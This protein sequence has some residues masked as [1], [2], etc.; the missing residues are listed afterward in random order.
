MSAP[1]RSCGYFGVPHL[2]AIFRTVRMFRKVVRTPSARSSTTFENV[3]S[4]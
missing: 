4:P 3:D 1:W 2:A